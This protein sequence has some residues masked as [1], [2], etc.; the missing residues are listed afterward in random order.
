MFSQQEDL[1]E[2]EGTEEASSLL[3]AV[4]QEG[5]L[6]D[7]SKIK[8]KGILQITA[9]TELKE[10]KRTLPEIRKDQQE[11]SKL[12][13]TSEAPRQKDSSSL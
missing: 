1:S 10:S 5:R 8:S 6:M 13:G 11:E 7:N 9:F 4:K 2:T 3:P 12:K